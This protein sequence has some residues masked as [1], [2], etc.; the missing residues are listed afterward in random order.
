MKA[1]LVQGGS[2]CLPYLVQILRAERAVCSQVRTYRHESVLARLVL[3]PDFRQAG[4]SGL[5]LAAKI[6]QSL[7][8]LIAPRQRKPAPLEVEKVLFHFWI[9]LRGRPA[10]AIFRV[11]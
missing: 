9:G 3:M 4:C 1:E 6:I 2:E 5:V 8:E 7:G 11:L 10:R